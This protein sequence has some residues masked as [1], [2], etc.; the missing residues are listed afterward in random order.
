[1]CVC[2]ILKFYYCS[3]FDTNTYEVY[4][5]SWFPALCSEIPTSVYALK[6]SSSVFTVIQTEVDA[7][8]LLF[9][10]FQEAYAFL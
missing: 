10:Y 4:I 5:R 3:Y 2:V 7:K 9:S 1:M 6:H 8:P